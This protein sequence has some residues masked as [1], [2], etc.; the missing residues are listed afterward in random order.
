[1]ATYVEIEYTVIDASMFYDTYL[2]KT[3]DII[4]ALKLI[5]INDKLD[6]DISGRCHHE[7]KFKNNNTS[8]YSYH[9]DFY[10]YFLKHSA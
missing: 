5:F 7:S 3:V 8:V 10:N 4:V 9:F 1:M 2:L 6:S